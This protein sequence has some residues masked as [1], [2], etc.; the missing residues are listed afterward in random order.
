MYIL[1]IHR[2]S[3]TIR[4]SAVRSVFPERFPSNTEMCNTMEAMIETKN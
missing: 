1:N 3:H 4:S 2:D